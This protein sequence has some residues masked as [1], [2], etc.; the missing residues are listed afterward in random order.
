MKD[1]VQLLKQVIKILR[2]MKIIFEVRQDLF[3]EAI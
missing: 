1:T 3:R 2:R